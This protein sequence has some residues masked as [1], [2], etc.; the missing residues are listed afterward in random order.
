MDE[1]IKALEHQTKEWKVREAGWIRKITDD[2]DANRIGKWAPKYL[3]TTLWWALEHGRTRNEFLELIYRTT[4][5]YRL[6]MMYRQAY[7]AAIE[8]TRTEKARATRER[9]LRAEREREQAGQ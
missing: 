9:N 1:D 5:E 7:L 3:Y 2:P 4:T 6:V 8:G